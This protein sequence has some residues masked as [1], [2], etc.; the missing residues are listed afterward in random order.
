M[1]KFCC[2]TDLIL[3]MMKE[4]ENLMK[5]SVL[6][7]DLFI[8]HDALRWYLVDVNCEELLDREF[9]LFILRP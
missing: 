3:F 1:S 2:I 8:V 6:E 4:A 5:G 7:D 9:I